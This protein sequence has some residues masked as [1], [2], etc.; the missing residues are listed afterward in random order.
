MNDM[1]LHRA[2][3]RGRISDSSSAGSFGVGEGEDGV[4]RAARLEG[5]G[6]LQVLALEAELRP[7]RGIQRV[8]GEHGGPLDEGPDPFV[9]GADGGEVEGHAGTSLATKRHKKTQKRG[10]VAR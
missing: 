9:G 2:I 8:V 6:G 4:A 3:E 1:A 5:A 7:V 10:W